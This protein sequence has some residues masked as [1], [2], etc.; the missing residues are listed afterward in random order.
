MVPSTRQT[1]ET[2]G[3]RKI[4]AVFFD[5]GSTLIKPEPDVAYV[6]CDIARAHGHALH[7]AEVLPHM[8][9]VDDFYEQE[10][11][12]NGDFWCSAAGSVQIW[13]DMYR[14][15]C[16]LCGLEHDEDAM[17]RDVYSCYTQGRFW[18]PYPDVRETLIQLKRAG[19]RL[20]IISNWDPALRGV[21]REMSLAPF[22][23]DIVCSADVGYRKPDA[24]IFKIAMERMGLAPDVCL[25]VGDLPEA[26]GEGA[27]AAGITPIIIDRDDYQLDCPYTRIKC[28]DRLPALIGGSHH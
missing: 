20:G 24:I 2:S 11:L 27:T 3:A 5:V 15:L 13:L 26:D 12:K 22:F 23:E 6:F 8:P 21:I 10:Y 7:V 4:E 14:Y 19:L 9:E 1:D 28:L 18:A 16:R 25:H 17:A